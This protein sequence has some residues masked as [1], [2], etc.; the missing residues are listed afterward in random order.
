MANDSKPV[1]VC[2]W[3]LCFTFDNFLRRWLQNPQKIMANYIKEGFKILDVGPGMGYFTI[4]MAKLT[5]PSGKV[6]AADL[7]KHML[8]AIYRRATRAGVQERIVLHQTTNEAIG[9]SGPV[10]FAL[11]FWMVHEV[12]DRKRLLSQIASALKQG[13]TFLLSEPKLHVSQANFNESVNFAKEAGL[14]LIDR[15]KIFISNSVLFKKP[16]LI[17]PLLK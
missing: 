6:T 10:D 13:G 16:A 2:P 1:E 7:Q 5:G 8:D 12:R 9:V 14:E 15:P 4:P 11:A 3:W 17:H